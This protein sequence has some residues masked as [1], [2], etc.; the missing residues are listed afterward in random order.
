MNLS[1]KELAYIRRALE[2]TLENSPILSNGFGIDLAAKVDRELHSV[3][4]V[5]AQ[6]KEI[7]STATKLPKKNLK[8]EDILRELKC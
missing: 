2:F 1:I 6:T 8:L 5:K 7:K 4:G 3:K